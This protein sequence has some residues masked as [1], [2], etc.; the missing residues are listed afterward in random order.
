MQ[1]ERAELELQKNKG[2]LERSSLTA[3]ERDKEQTMQ[4]KKPAPKCLESSDYFMRIKKIIAGLKKASPGK[5]G[6]W[7]VEKANDV[8]ING[9]QESGD[10]AEASRDGHGGDDID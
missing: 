3:S 4:T 5:S 2:S 9:V 6:A 8:M 1:R 10:H 7:Y